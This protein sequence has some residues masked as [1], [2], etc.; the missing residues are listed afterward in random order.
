MWTWSPSTCQKR[1][2]TTAMSLNVG[3]SITIRV[4]CS[5]TVRATSSPGLAVSGCWYGTSCE[6]LYD[7][8]GKA[9]KSEADTTGCPTFRKQN[10]TLYQH[11]SMR[12]AAQQ[13]SKYPLRTPRRLMAPLVCS[14]HT[15]PAQCAAFTHLIQAMEQSWQR[16]DECFFSKELSNKNFRIYSW[17]VDTFWNPEQITG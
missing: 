5:W 12:A 3:W 9:W 6:E 10:A 11:V 13:P 7:W 4:W 2:S 15:C 8:D 1:Y 17:K 14:L 16:D